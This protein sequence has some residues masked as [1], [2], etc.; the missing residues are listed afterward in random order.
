LDLST[1]EVALFR[2]VR[3]APDDFLVLISIHHIV[4]DGISFEIIWRDIGEFYAA[5]LSGRAP[6]LPPLTMTYA[7]FA[8]EEWRQSRENGFA[9]HIAY[10]CET[11]ADAPPLLEL[12]SDRT[13]PPVASTRGA[14]YRGALGPDVVAGL[15]ETA[16]AEG[17]TLFMAALAVWQ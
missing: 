4:T 11:L 2:I 12:P 17:A 9:P 13:R 7:D 14:R 6:N 3:F 5:R 10:W 1:G 16:R 8:A 15:R